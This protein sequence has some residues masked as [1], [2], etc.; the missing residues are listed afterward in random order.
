MLAFTLITQQYA[1]TQPNLDAFDGR[2]LELEAVLDLQN[3]TKQWLSASSY[4]LIHFL[5][6]F[7]TKKNM[8]E[9]RPKP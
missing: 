8:N 2:F 3:S 1:K 5:K 7:G 6:N 4:I 9:N